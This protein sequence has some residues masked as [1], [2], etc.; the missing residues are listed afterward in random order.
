MKSLPYIVSKKALTDLDDIWYYTVEKWSVDQA[1]RYADFVTQSDSCIAS[2]GHVI[3]VKV[4]TN[5]QL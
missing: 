1:N 3:C 5:S 4:V 2:F